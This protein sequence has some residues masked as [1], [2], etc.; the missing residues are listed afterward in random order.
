MVHG[1]AVVMGEI[2]RSAA[3]RM[4]DTLESFARGLGEQISN[5]ERRRLMRAARRLRACV[6]TRGRAP[7]IDRMGRPSGC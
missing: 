5:L 1:R 4:A 6:A 3:L 2:D 7:R